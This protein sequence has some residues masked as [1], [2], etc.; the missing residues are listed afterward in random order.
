MVAQP[1]RKNFDLEHLQEKPALAKAGVDPGFPSGNAATQKCQ[2]G[3][4]PSQCE[5]ALE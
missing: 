1:L 4:C 3:F 2:S 5:T